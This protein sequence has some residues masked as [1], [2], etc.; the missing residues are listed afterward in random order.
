MTKTVSKNLKKN[1]YVVAVFDHWINF[2]KK[3]L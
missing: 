3:N 1:K 2:E